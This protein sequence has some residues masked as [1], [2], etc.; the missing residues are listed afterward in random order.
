[1]SQGNPKDLC[2]PCEPDSYTVEPANPSCL[3]CT[4]CVGA[5]ILVKPCT[6]SSDT[7]CGCKPGK[8]CGDAG[9]SF[10]V[11]ECG[12]G[13]EPADNRTCRDC[14]EGTFNDKIHEKC[15]PW[16]KSCPDPNAHIESKGD[17]FNDIKCSTPPENN[18]TSSI[19]TLESHQKPGD[20]PRTLRSEPGEYSYHQ[21]EQ[22]QGSSSESLATSHASK[23]P[24][25]V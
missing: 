14:P 7:V 9:C 2:T 22:E 4:Q 12:K 24:L 20:E 15:I 3:S 13:Q 8:K 19:T 25:L 5:Q 16:H 1:M 10:C 21:P 6:I 18:S 11:Q 17:A 23:D